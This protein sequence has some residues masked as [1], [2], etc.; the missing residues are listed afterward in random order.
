MKRSSG[1]KLH[2]KSMFDC[3]RNERIRLQVM[4]DASLDAH[5]LHG[6]NQ[7]VPAFHRAFVRILLVPIVIPCM[8]RVFFTTTL[9]LM[10]RILIIIKGAKG[11]KE[12]HHLIR[13]RHRR[14][15]YH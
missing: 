5:F 4:H 11:V 3:V 2:N 1:S 9:L 13:R 8:F 7:R 14:H 6:V 12:K 15:C 10:I